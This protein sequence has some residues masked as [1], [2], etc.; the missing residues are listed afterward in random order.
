MEE[1]DEAEAVVV[2]VEEEEEGSRWK[3]LDV[4]EW[5]MGRERGADFI[6]P[7]NT[8]IV[9]LIAYT[10]R[11]ARSQ[12]LLKWLVTRWS[13]TRVVKSNFKISSGG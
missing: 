9:T 12:G 10:H 2:V 3:P 13:N 8:L 5:E 7:Y 11:S 1:E 6:R 4:K